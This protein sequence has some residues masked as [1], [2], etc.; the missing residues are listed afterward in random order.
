MRPVANRA[1]GP[2]SSQ[3]AW[4]AVMK[5]AVSPASA[6]APSSS[7]GTSVRRCGFAGDSVTAFGHAYGGGSQ[8]FSMWVHEP[9]Y[10]D[11]QSLSM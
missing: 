6:A 4:P 3:P 11:A 10:V 7:P 9:T 1:T 8:F 5:P 2:G